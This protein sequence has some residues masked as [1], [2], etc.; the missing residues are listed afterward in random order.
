MWLNCLAVGLGGFCGAVFRYLLGFLP[1][2][3]Y[4]NMPLGTMW[5]NLI[6]AFC[7]GMIAGMIPAGVLSA[8]QQLFL[9]TGLCG[10]FTTFSTFSLETLQLLEQ[11]HVLEAGVY[12]VGSVIACLLG[13]FFGKLL[14][15]RLFV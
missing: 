15:T 13:V 14:A 4:L 11:Q 12:A 8:R 9:K 3:Y 10:G 5:I 1:G 7:I 2:Y 6:G